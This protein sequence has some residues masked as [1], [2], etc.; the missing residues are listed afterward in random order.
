MTTTTTDEPTTAPRAAGIL[1]V[2]GDRILL[3]QRAGDCDFSGTWGLP[4]GKIEDGETPLSAAV[5]ETLEETGHMVAGDILPFANDDGCVTFLASVDEFQPD[6]N[7]EHTAYVW[8]DLS[9]LPQP[10]HPSLSGL[11]ELVPV[12]DDA[13][14]FD[15][16]GFMMISANPISKVGVFPYIG[17]KIPGAAEKDRIYYVFRP[18]E[19]LSDPECINSFKLLPWIDN[20]AMLG[21]ED[22]G[23]TPAEKKGV[24]GV[25]GEN[26]FF[27]GGTLYANLK[28]F[29]EALA[30]LIDSGKTELS[31][32]YRARYEWTSGTWQG[33]HYDC[34]QRCLR[35]NHLALVE[36]GRMGPE[37][38][39]LDSMTFTIDSEDIM[40]KKELAQLQALM[41]ARTAKL[42]RVA[43]VQD[44]EDAGK[45]NAE[46]A[47]TVGEPGEN[48]NETDDASKAADEAKNMTV[49]EAVA[50]IEAL[51]PLLEKLITAAGLGAAPVQEAVEQQTPAVAVMDSADVQVK[52]MRAIAQRDSLAKQL[53]THVGVFDHADMTL[54][55]VVKYGVEKLEIT[56]PKGQ[57][58]AVL[59]GYLQAAKAPRF[60]NVTDSADVPPKDNAVARFLKR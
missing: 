24:H 20:H 9:N 11:S 13:R 57:E 37:V 29:S 42:T 46:D 55:D 48:P 4:F 59:T 12:M 18:P 45:E 6:L 23:N 41:K 30:D 17:A 1:F 25:M 56:A 36:T 3:M 2:A 8:S 35:G 44:A 22:L 53:S 32:G 16:N 34:I 33:Q 43:P 54:A 38:A 5:R 47:P 49:T 27:E 52:V 15:F 7:D 40:T 28:V 50:A 19:E 31:A 21:P 58:H 26:V 10:L 51:M 60:A 14:E 39:V